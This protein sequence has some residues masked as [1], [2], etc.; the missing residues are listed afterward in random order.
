[1]SKGAP[2]ILVQSVLPSSGHPGTYTIIYNTVLVNS[3]E[4]LSGSS[5]TSL[6]YGSNMFK[7]QA[8][9]HSSVHPSKI[10]G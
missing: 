3:H 5:P 9:E 6:G 4:N 7:A 10:D 2:G 1:M 8:G